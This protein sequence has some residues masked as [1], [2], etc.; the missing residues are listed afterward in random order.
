MIAYRT[1]VN[2]RVTKVT[3]L[4]IFDL[5]TDLLLKNSYSNDIH[6]KFYTFSLVANKTIF[7]VKDQAAVAK[8]VSCI[9]ANHFLFWKKKNCF[10]NCYS[11]QS[12]Q[13]TRQTFVIKQMWGKR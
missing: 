3:F 9:H 10:L 2:K 6:F 7:K 1:D 11:E 8:F 12:L 13:I 5:N 4:G